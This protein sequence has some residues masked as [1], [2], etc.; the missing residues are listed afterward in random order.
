MSLFQKLIF[1]K[2]SLASLAL[3]IIQII[4]NAQNQTG[5]LFR[6]AES[7]AMREYRKAQ[8]AGESKPKVLLKLGHYHTIRGLSWS[9]IS[10]LGNFVSEFAKSN[11]MNS[12][13]LAMYVNNA[14]GDYA[15]LSANADL[16]TL[17]DIT[18]KDKWT[19]YDLRPLRKYFQAGQT[20]ITCIN[21]KSVCRSFKQSQNNYRITQNI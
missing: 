6:F 3:M 16:K 9:N 13:H 19:V 18:P 5:Q 8:A 10:T 7:S 14:S 2:I 17:A 20:R 4:V 1:M 21:F 11:D 15:I 12:F